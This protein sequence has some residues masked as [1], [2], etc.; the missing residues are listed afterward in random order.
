MYTFTPNF[1]ANKKYK[2]HS[3]PTGARVVPKDGTG[4]RCMN[5]WEFHYQNWE[6]TVPVLETYARTGAVYG[7]LKPESQKGCLDVNLLKK[8]GLTA[9]RVLNDPMFFY[10]ML[11]PFCNPV[12]S[13]IDDDHRMP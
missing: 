10:Q 1:D 2:F 13:G 11:F 4:K 7:N 8:H 6:A 12:E 3:T 5:G 9:A